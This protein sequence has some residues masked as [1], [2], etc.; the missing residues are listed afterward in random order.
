MCKCNYILVTGGT[1]MVG[2]ALQQV[3]PDATFISS[4]DY[5]LR[6]RRHTE[7]MFKTYAPE[8]VIHLAA[9]VGGIKANMEIIL[10]DEEIF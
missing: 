7:E 8:Q 6:D 2:H 1:G 5:D 10:I 4:T 3:I 9:R